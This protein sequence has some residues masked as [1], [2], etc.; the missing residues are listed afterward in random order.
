MANFYCECCGAK[1]TDVRTLTSST[2]M[3]SQTKR[4]IL[5]EGGEKSQYICKYCGNK[6]SD[7]R[8]LVSSICSKSPC[9][10]HRAAL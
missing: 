8:T 9:K 4:H 1:Y 5:Y 3:K 6:Y 7:L 2:C 10:Y